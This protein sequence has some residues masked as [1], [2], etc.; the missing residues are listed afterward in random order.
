MQDLW[1]RMDE[2]FLVILT[3]VLGRSCEPVILRMLLSQYFCFSPNHNSQTLPCACDGLRLWRISHPCLNSSKHHL[4]VSTRSVP[5][6]VSSPSVGTNSFVFAPLSRA[7][8]ICLGPVG[9]SQVAWG[10][11]HLPLQE[12]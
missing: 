11:E 9:A 5:K 7:E 4:Y 10:K 6:W 12:T 2:R 3:S 8:Y 1:W